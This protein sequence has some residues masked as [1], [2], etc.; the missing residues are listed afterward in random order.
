MFNPEKQDGHDHTL[1]PLIT[2][3]FFFLLSSFVFEGATTMPALNQILSLASVPHTRG[4]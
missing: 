3:V 4:I 1:A 2:V